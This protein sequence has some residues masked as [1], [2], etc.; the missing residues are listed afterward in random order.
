MSTYLILGFLI[1]FIFFGLL[2]FGPW[3]YRNKIKINNWVSRRYF[4]KGAFQSYQLHTNLSQTL[5]TK[6][7]VQEILQR[8]ENLEKQVS[9]LNK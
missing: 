8:L 9:N 2:I 4:G 7:D 5:A 6:E 1:L 3:F